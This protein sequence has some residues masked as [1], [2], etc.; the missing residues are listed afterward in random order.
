[1]TT[2]PELFRDALQS[3]SI[4]NVDDWWGNLDDAAR[5]EAVSFWES[6][7]SPYIVG[8]HIEAYPEE[9]TEDEESKA[10]YWHNDFYEYLINHEVRWFEEPIYHIC[11]RT[12]CAETAIRRGVIPSS[13][14]CPI[15]DRDCLMKKILDRAGGKGVRLRI[16]PSYSGD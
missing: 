16:V 4:L 5:R 3:S 6:V 7:A 9:D 12:S 2:I 10:G 14:D 11:H 15:G 1:M 13:F 8:F